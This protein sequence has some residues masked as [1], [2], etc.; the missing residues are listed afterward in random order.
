MRI[1]YLA[2][3]RYIGCLKALQYIINCMATNIS[4]STS[5]V[6]VLMVMFWKEGSAVPTNGPM[7]GAKFQVLLA[8]N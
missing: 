4:S 5:T 3:D 7:L 6:S 1:E 2:S 8:G